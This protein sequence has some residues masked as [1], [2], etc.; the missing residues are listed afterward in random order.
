MRN[1]ST[2]RAVAALVLRDLGCTMRN[3]TALVCTAVGLAICVFYG[4]YWSQD[5]ATGTPF[6]SFIIAMAAVVPVLEAGE[7]ITLF[8]M[9]E[10]MAHNSY[11][12]I[13]RTGTSLGAIVAA[14]T[15]AGCVV[16]GVLAALCFLGMGI[17][18]WRLSAIAAIT[19]VG[20]IPFLL[21][22]SGCG[23]ISK[24]QMKVNFWAWPLVLGGLLPVVAAAKPEWAF[25]ALLSPLGFQV[26]E[27]LEAVSGPLSVFDLGHPALWVSFAAWLF[28]SALWLRYCMNKFHADE[29]R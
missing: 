28:V 6:S 27:C 1:P 13:L 8:A 7:M 25:L 10:E 21:L 12:A 16:S 4:R 17:G 18:G 20:S 26:V 29:R 9:S 11:P 3:P 24:D 23:L 22:S 14:K 15:I 2:P 19:L 5:I